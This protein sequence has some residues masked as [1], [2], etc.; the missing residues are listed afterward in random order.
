M[1]KHIDFNTIAIQIVLSAYNLKKC[2]YVVRRYCHGMKII[3]I[4][5]HHLLAI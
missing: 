4:L 5:P 1:H 3:I 2:V